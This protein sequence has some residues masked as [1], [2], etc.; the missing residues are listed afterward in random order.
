MFEIRLNPINFNILH[1]T[2]LCSCVK[3]Q[4]L[5][6]EKTTFTVLKRHIY[7]LLRS[8][9]RKEENHVAPVLMY[10]EKLSKY[11]PTLQQKKIISQ[12]GALILQLKRFH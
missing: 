5:K 2:L 7:T 9:V 1:F 6:R 3:S 12:C 8:N 11:H 4:L 10:K